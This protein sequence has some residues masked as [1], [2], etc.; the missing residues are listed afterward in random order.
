MNVSLTPELESFVTT[1]VGSGLYGSQSEVVREG[2]R[3][4]MERDRLTEAR[5]Q[6]LRAE[7]ADGLEQARRGELIPGEE[8]RDRIR[9]KSRDRRK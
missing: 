8:V 5:L 9:Q 6:D 1:K 3:L 4:L 7:V 2:L